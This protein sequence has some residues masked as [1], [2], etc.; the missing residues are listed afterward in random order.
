MKYS[1]TTPVGLDKYIQTIQNSIY[2]RIQSLWTLTEAQ[3]LSFGRVY[4]IIEEGNTFYRWYTSGIDYIDP[5]MDDKYAVTFFFTEEG[6]R[7]FD[8]DFETEIG[9]VFHVNLSTLKPS[10]THRADEEVK[11]DVYKLLKPSERFLGFSPS[12]LDQRMD[13]QPWHTFKVNLKLTY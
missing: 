11:W 6:D 12:E 3:I 4:K 8:T 1:K 7:N 2:E 10:I 5:L 9:L 13:L